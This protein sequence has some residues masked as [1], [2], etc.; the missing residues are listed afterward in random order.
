MQALRRHRGRLS[1]WLIALV[2][3]TQLATAAYACPQLSSVHGDGV[4]AMAAMPDCD[5]S[6]PTRMDPERPQLC[7]AHCETGK[8][9]VNSPV[10]APD[11]PPAL[12]VGAALVG[13]VDVADAAALAA[14]MP[15]SVA[16]GPPVGSPPLYLSLL[17][18]RN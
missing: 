5:G 14:S 6:V 8:T 7:K 18:L 13:I 4:A 11:A 17:V 10:A 16:D 15:A 12:A 9:S 3:F 1:G 2:L